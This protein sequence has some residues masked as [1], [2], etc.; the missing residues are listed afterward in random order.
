MTRHVGGARSLS[1]ITIN[2]EIRLR[3]LFSILKGYEILY[4]YPHTMYAYKRWLYKNKCIPVVSLQKQ[5]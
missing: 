4:S 2:D 3:E 1:G 5:L